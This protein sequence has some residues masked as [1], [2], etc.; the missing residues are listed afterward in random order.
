MDLV[1][2]HLN[3]HQTYYVVGAIVFVALLP[4]VYLTRRWSVPLIQYTLETIIYIVLMHFALG[5]ITRVAA[6]FKDQSSMKRAFGTQNVEAPDW[7]NPWL[8]FW[9]RTAYHPDWL[10]WFEIVAAVLIV[11]LVWRFRPMRVRRRPQKKPSEAARKTYGY[12]A[13]ERGKMAHR[14][15]GRR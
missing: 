10:F 9:D 12:T 5:V 11:P 6:W 14:G 4:V 7:Q 2:E 15:S 3:E 13:S 8:T 1:L